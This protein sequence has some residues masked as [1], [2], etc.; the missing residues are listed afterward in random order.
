LNDEP[1]LRSP[2]FPDQEVGK[3]KKTELL[4]VV[5]ESL[6]MQPGGKFPV[7]GV[8][9]MVNPGAQFV[10]IIQRQDIPGRVG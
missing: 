2:Q 7:P 6:V 1:V 8:H 5:G 3:S 10:L 9:N 4:F